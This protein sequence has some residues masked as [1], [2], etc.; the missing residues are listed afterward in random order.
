TRKPQY[1][2]LNSAMTTFDEVPTVVRCPLIFLYVIQNY[3]P[4]QVVGRIEILRR[5]QPYESIP[6]PYWRDKLGQTF[7]LGHLPRVSSFSR[8]APCRNEPGSECMDFLRVHFKK[9]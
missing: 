6:L 5:R 9:Q 2:T 3:V 8:F 1:A 7:N 4:E